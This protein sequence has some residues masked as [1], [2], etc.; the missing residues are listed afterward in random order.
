MDPPPLL[1]L[2]P[3]LRLPPL[4]LPELRLPPEFDFDLLPTE[5]ELRVVVPLFREEPDFGF[6]VLPRVLEP[7]DVLLRELGLMLPEDP[8]RVPTPELFDRLLRGRTWRVRS[9]R[10]VGWPERPEFQTRVPLFL[11]SVGLMV[12]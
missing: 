8:E 12:R 2:P 7:L 10:S 11:E 5:P 4:L 6:T 9:L 3:E 1:R